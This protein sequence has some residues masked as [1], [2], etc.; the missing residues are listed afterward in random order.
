MILLPLGK[1]LGNLDSF[2]PIEISSAEEFSL[3]LLE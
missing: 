1:I 3:G 2:V